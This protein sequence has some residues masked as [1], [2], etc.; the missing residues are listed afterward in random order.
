MVK[1]G[2]WRQVEDGNKNGDGVSGGE[3][4]HNIAIR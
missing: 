4:E 2:G 3:K 1:S